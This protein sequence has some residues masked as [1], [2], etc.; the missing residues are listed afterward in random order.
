MTDLGRS[1]S[2]F[3]SFS[4]K[5]T[6]TSNHKFK[7]QFSPYNS[8]AKIQNFWNSSWDLQTELKASWTLIVSKR[9]SQGIF[10]KCNQSAASLYFL[11]LD[12]WKNNLL[13]N[14]GKGKVMVAWFS[15]IL[16]ARVL[17]TYILLLLWENATF[18]CSMFD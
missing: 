17:S 7:N 18:C 11:L 8:S 12:V 16:L 2:Y 4:P 6:Y 14:V 3:Q 10:C 15:V 1:P 13:Q 5:L 9:K